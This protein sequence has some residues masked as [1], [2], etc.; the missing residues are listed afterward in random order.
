MNKQNKLCNLWSIAAALLLPLAAPAALACS[1]DA[2]LLLSLDVRAGALA[3]GSDRDS[4][5]R[6]HA[7]GCAQIYRPAYLRNPGHY[8]AVLDS[9]TLQDLRT[10]LAGE[11]LRKFDA[12]QV[13][14]QLKTVQRQR[15]TPLGQG[16]LF[17]V[18][19][20]DDYQ[21]RW[22]QAG[23]SRG[24]AWKAL[25]EYARAW[26]IRTWR[27][28]PVC[29]AWLRAPPTPRPAPTASTKST[30]VPTASMARPTTCA[31]TR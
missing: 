8:R 31:A 19:D 7:D 12:D 13:H 14:A 6:V 15:S 20:A 21:L 26:T 22:T 30:P 4:W 29:R 25:P 9:V 5:V 24:A 10:R 2:P 17:I 1:T 11:S 16:E 18:S 23:A 27:W 28:N 3:A